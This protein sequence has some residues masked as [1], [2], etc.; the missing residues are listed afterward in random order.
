M[1]PGEPTLW[2]YQP[3]SCPADTFSASHL[4]LPA[5]SLNFLFHKIP[6]APP[7][8]RTWGSSSQWGPTCKLVESVLPS[9]GWCQGAQPGEQRAGQR[10]ASCPFHSPHLLAGPI[11]LVFKTHPP[12]STNSTQLV[13]ASSIPAPD[14]PC[15]PRQ[16]GLPNLEF[17]HAPSPAYTPAM[18]PQYPFDR[19]QP[20][21][22]ILRP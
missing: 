16:E 14:S 12:L 11:S 1:T 20:L 10:S 3:R 6:V 8:L 15:S 19:A 2:P 13:Q 21:N 18:A 7:P 22:P 17:G 5:S 9:G 4:S